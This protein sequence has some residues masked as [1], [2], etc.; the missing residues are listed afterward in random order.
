MESENHHENADLE[1]MARKCEVAPP[2][3]PGDPNRLPSRQTER[4]HAQCDGRVLDVPDHSRLRGGAGVCA[5][6]FRG[7]RRQTI[8]AVAPATESLAHLP[9]QGAG[10]RRALPAG[11][12]NSVCVSGKLAGDAGEHPSAVS[13]ADEPSL[14]GRHPL[15]AG[16][17]LRGHARGSARRA[18]VW[19][20]SSGRRSW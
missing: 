2:A 16:L 5:G 14:A 15:G 17:L 13:V 3:E 6:L 4:G 11:V 19:Q 20:P 7:P 8:A 10:R 9:G 12:G 1:R 18:L